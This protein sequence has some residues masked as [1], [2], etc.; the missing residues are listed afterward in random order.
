MTKASSKFSL[1]QAVQPPLENFAFVEE[2]ERQI[3]A[4]AIWT[5]IGILVDEGN[6]ATLILL[7]ENGDTVALLRFCLSVSDSARAVELLKQSNGRVFFGAWQ[8]NTLTS[9][10]IQ[11]LEQINQVWRNIQAQ[12]REYSTNEVKEYFRRVEEGSLQSGRNVPFSQATKRAV[13]LA[14]H[15]RCMFKG[16]GE[17]L[18]FDQLTGTEGNFSY[19]A[20]NVASSERGPR[21]IMGLSE[22]LSDDPGNVLLLCDKHHRL[23]DKVAAADYTAEYLSR[24]RREFCETVSRLLVGLSYQPIP[25]FAVLWPLNQQTIAPPTSLQVAQSLAKIHSR[26]DQQLNIV[27]DNDEMVRQASLDSR[28]KF[29]PRLIE[30]TAETIRMQAG[31]YK[32]RAALFA[33]GLMP[34]LI[35]LGAKL[36]NKNEIIPMLRY[37]DGGQWTWPSDIPI[38]RTYE[39]TGLEGL[40]DTESEI[41]LIVALTADPEPPNNLARDLLETKGI[42]YIKVLASAEHMGNAAIAHP[43]DGKQFSTEIQSLLHRLSDKHGVKLIHVLPCASNAACVFFGQAYDRH[44][45]ELLVY[46]FTPGGMKP[47]IL[48]RND[49]ESCHLSAPSRALLS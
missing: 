40:A 29:L 15:G 31:G 1:N 44:H 11:S 17:D 27:A 34:S 9:E 6:K 22:K 10:M 28:E 20:H 48:I 49:G 5:D 21:G 46:D 13:M 2:Y 41:A 42:R 7:L 47:Q 8:G 37:R 35:A 32:Q 36:G 30:K 33:F 43:T 45:P 14:S 19:L 25:A 23:I 38:G 39:I 3:R 4:T 26:L 24:M 18:Q 16:C 12:V